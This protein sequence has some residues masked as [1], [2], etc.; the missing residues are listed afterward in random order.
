MASHSHQLLRG[1]YQPQ[2]VRR[3][4]IPK[5]DGGL[6]KLGI[7]TALDRFIQQAVL[8]VLQRRWAHVTEVGRAPPRCCGALTL[9]I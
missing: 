1:T 4:E 5:A 7:P 3:V 8:Q 9:R 6:R 2:S